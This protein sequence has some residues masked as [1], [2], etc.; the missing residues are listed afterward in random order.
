MFR[1]F[2]MLLMTLVAATEEPALNETAPPPRYPLAR[3]FVIPEHKLFV[4][5]I[6]K[7][8][9]SQLINA[10]FEAANLTYGRWSDLMPPIGTP[11]NTAPWSSSFEPKFLREQVFGY[12]SDYARVR[13]SL[14]MVNSTQALFAVLCLFTDV[15]LVLLFDSSC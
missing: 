12:R 2:S 9:C 14:S 13:P 8:G 4:C 6:L 10:A 1:A 7:N 3:S 11:P 5:Y 15:T